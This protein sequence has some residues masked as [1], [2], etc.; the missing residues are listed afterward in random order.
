MAKKIGVIAEDVSDVLVITEIIGKYIDRNKF[1]IRKFV[2][3]GSGKLRNKCGVWAKQLLASGCDHILVFHDLDRNNSDELMADIL[4]KVT[5]VKFPRSIIV[6]PKEEIEAWLLSDAKAI[7]DVFKL[8][9]MPTRISDC[10]TV[11]SPK[12]Y[13]RDIV[14]RMGRTRYLN[15]RHNTRLAASSSVTNLLRCRSYRP[16]DKYIRENIC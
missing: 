13:L 12:E 10:E 16:L 3:N 1:S 11:A 2:G 4:S 6:I 14:W 9:K 8:E 5:R 15:S 7:K